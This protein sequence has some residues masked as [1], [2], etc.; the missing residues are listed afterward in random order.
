[1]IPAQLHVR[2]GHTRCNTGR[3]HN[4]I[5]RCAAAVG[6][7]QR[8][9]AV[10]TL[11]LVELVVTARVCTFRLYFSPPNVQPIVVECCR[12]LQSASGEL[13]GVG[14]T[15]SMDGDYPAIAD[16]EVSR[17]AQFHPNFATA[18][19]FF[20]H[21]VIIITVTYHTLTCALNSIL[22][23]C[24]DVKCGGEPACSTLASKCNCRQCELPNLGMQL[25]SETAVRPCSTAHFY[26]GCVQRRRVHT[27]C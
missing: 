25:V 22:A 27:H 16:V 18:Q 10:S 3:T 4:T 8:R 2:Y 9:M 6:L 5:T 17:H 21:T 26:N 13:A 14:I 24:R 7:R 20:W 15:I 1:M 12:L 19:P 11:T 23:K